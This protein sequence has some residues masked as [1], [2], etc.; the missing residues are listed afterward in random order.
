MSSGSD[1]PSK[2]WY[3]RITRSSAPNVSPVPRARSRPST[4]RKRSGNP[5]RVNSSTASA[6]VAYRATPT[7]F[8]IIAPSPL[9]RTD[10]LAEARRRSGVLA[11]VDG[12]VDDRG[13]ATGPPLSEFGDQPRPF[14]GPVISRAPRSQDT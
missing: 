3:S 4:T 12:H 7:G 8:A 1:T 6:S 9:D 13:D 14:Q 5:R 10:E 11:V 2:R